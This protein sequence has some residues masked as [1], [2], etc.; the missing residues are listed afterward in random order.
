MPADGT[1]PRRRFVID[2]FAGA[3]GAST[4]LGQALGRPVDIAVNHSAEALAIHRANHKG[5]I[6]LEEDVFTV[7]WRK[8]IGDDDDVD[9]IWAS[10]DCKHF[11]TAKGGKPVDKHIRGLAWSLTRHVEQLLPRAFG[12]E[13]VPPFEGWGPLHA[14]GT[15][16]DDG[17]DV[18]GTPID[19]RRGQTFRQWIKRFEEMG[20]LVDW[21]VLNAADYGAPTTRK[22]LYFV[23]RRD[24]LPMWPTP[25]H[26]SPKVLAAAQRDLFA[27]AS[28]LPWRPAY[29][30]IDWSNLGTSIFERAEP[31]ED[32]TN[33]R[34][35]KGYWKYV[36]NNP[37]P[38][39]LNVRHQGPAR[40]YAIG[41]PLPTTPASDVEIGLVVP[42]IVPQGWGERKTQQP[43][44]M[45]IERPLSTVV[46][47]GEKHALVAAWLTVLRNNCDGADV[48]RPLPTI[49]AGGEHIAACRA[50][51]VKYY[52][53]GDAQPVTAPLGTVTTH[54]RFGLVTVAGDQYV[55]ADIFFRM[56]TPRE[57][58][59]AQGFDDD[60]VLDPINP[61]TGKPLSKKL[62]VRGIG[63]SVC[64]AVARAIYSA[65]MVR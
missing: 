14:K 32:N 36:V 62:Q 44:T 47:D 10:P 55:L 48:R 27:P 56:L 37:S 39:L 12:G 25:T 30:V 54:D 8:Y 51:L 59:R 11:S 2:A 52:G 17:N 15:I 40:T 13:N 41:S 64:P 53:E 6:H 58:A 35:A 49:C 38:F 46:G 3:G 1:V 33:R 4:G 23:G 26:A 65:N 43:R 22:R 18:G 31:L 5:T 45:S 19:S 57:L 16:D 34:I 9:W 63:N 20:Y 60:Y 29:E 42:F 21:K 61:L 7:K 28:L 50:F 24:G